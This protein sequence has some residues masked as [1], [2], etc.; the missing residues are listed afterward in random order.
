MLRGAA[1]WSIQMRTLPPI[2]GRGVR[3]MSVIGDRRGGRLSGSR[4]RK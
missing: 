3:E 4:C 2:P 1:E